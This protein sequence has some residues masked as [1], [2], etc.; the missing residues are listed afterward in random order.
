MFDADTSQCPGGSKCTYTWTCTV[1]DA[2]GDEVGT[3]DKTGASIKVTSGGSARSDVNMNLVSTPRS[4]SC[5]CMI[6]DT[7]SRGFSTAEGPFEVQVVPAA[8]SCAVA[9][10]PKA[11]RVRAHA[12]ACLRA[13]AP[14]ARR[15][16]N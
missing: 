6:E 16:P 15:P 14:L 10:Q 3:F 4:V 8:P 7:D 2:E 1:T 5:L 13:A 11:I 12:R 9:P